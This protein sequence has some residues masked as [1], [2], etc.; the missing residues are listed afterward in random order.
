LSV[1]TRWGWSGWLLN[2]DKKSDFKITL[3]VNKSHETVFGMH[4][5][6]GVQNR[7]L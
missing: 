4:C 7:S 1:G 3:E 2:L 5:S 6:C